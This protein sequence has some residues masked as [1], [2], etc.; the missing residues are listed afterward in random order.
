M[1]SNVANEG[2]GVAAAFSARSLSPTHW[3]SHVSAGVSALPLLTSLAAREEDGAR[4]ALDACAR[5]MRGVLAQPEGRGGAG[6]D[7]GAW[8]WPAELCGA[9]A[10]ATAAT[11]A[12]VVPA[13]DV[14]RDG[15][16]ASVVASRDH[17]SVGADAARRVLESLPSRS[18]AVG[19]ARPEAAAWWKVA[20]GEAAAETGVGAEG[21]SPRHTALVAPLPIKYGG[22][23]TATG[24]SLAH[25]DGPALV[26]FG[27][28]LSSLFLHRRVREEGGAYGA[29]ADHG[30]CTFTQWSFYDPHV[31]EVRGYCCCCG[32]PL[33][34][35]LQLTLPPQTA[36][37]FDE[38]LQWARR[39][40]FSERD[41]QEALLSVFAQ[42]DAPRAPSATGMTHFL[43]G[44]TDDMRQAR[45][46][47]YLAVS[48]DRVA[49][50]VE[51][52]LPEAMEHA[53]TAFL[54]PGADAVP[55]GWSSHTL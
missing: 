7:L 8:S 12:P 6:P 25:R 11:V 20:A 44:I 23:S 17:V 36:Q 30:N 40:E 35:A 24:V 15:A 53:H 32:R 1:S 33:P 46:E 18:A 48:A 52:Y 41:V 13:F 10:A 50:A 55:A 21:T 19:G 14:R 22:W 29:G 34:R 49:D 4:E 43:H 42:V 2:H 54:V 38:A 39:R 26:V 9:G 28:L 3:F 16:V 27:E 47:Q 5:I 31:T 51:R 37:C 45:R